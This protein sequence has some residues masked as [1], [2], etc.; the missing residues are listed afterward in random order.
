ML[1][2]CRHLFSSN[3]CDS[4][5]GFEIT[6][7]SRLEKAPPPPLTGAGLPCRSHSHVPSDWPRGRCPELTRLVWA[8]RGGHKL[9]Q[10]ERPPPVA[11]QQGPGSSGRPLWWWSWAPPRTR[12]AAGYAPMGGRLWEV[13]G[14][15]AETE[16]RV[17]N[18]HT[19][20][21]KTHRRREARRPR[22]GVCA[23]C[24]PPA[25]TRHKQEPTASPHFAPARA[26]LRLPAL[27]RGTA[28]T[29][30]GPT[31]STAHPPGAANRS[32]ARN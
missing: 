13:T 21:L 6:Q 17:F 25:R 24:G 22:A 4:F 18:S 29:G 10:P 3:R 5:F 31:R 1:D 26:S 2:S 20:C 30:G 9:G 7:M 27:R 32:E 14:L 12:A 28:S 16:S 19:T 23:V 8:Q 15:Q 11:V